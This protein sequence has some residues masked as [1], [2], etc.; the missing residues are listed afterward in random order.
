MIQGL[1]NTYIKRRNYD[2]ELKLRYRH[3]GP[4][5][6]LISRSLVDKNNIFFDETISANDVMFSMKVAFFS[7]KI[8]VS[9]CMIYTLTRTP[10]SL[11][12]TKDINLLVSKM[13]VHENKIDFLI[14]NLK[15]EDFKKVY[16][17]L[18]W[19]YKKALKVR[20]SEEE[21]SFIKESLKRIDFK[22]NNV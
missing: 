5:C 4:W 9:S 8:D 12:T 1:I 6:K 3:I 19:I 18:G 7:K 16:M 11:T 14:S 2:N 13:R 20:Y 21:I 22:V 15:R 10:N 17:S